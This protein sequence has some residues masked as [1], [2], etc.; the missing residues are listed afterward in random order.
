MQQKRIALI[1]YL[2]AIATI[3]VIITHFGFNTKNFPLFSYVVQGSVPIFLFLSGFN[4]AMSFSRKNYTSLK[5][6]YHP[7]RIWKSAEWLLIPYAVAYFFEV[8]R[9]NAW[10][11]VLNPKSFLY[12]FFTGGIKGGIHGGYFI[13]VYWQFILLAPLFFL[14]VRKWKEKGLLL[15]LGL[16]LLYELSVHMIPVPQETNRLLI[17]RYLFLI[18]FGMY[19]FYH[20]KIH[21]VVL[22]MLFACGFTY[23]TAIDYFKFRWFLNTYWRNTS[24]YSIGY[25]I[26][27]LVVCFHLFEDKRLPGIAHKIVTQVGIS[28]FH[29]FLVQMVFY[30]MEWNNRFHL[31]GLP[32]GLH[33]LANC[34]V[35]VPIGMLWHYLESL[36]RRRFSKKPAKKQAEAGKA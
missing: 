27:I 24:V 16:D 7:L 36:L 25:F 4:S 13:C 8:W 1:D 31:A 19:F 2:K 15:L 21:P 11:Y 10:E 18:G 5:Q 28:S 22:A 23:I 35:C 17:F 32:M 6:F 9:R 3:L 34:L 14:L 20:R 33:I 29:I 30:R 26:A 12:T